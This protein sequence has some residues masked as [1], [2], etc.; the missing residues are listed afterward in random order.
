MDP[1]SPPKGEDLSQA[2]QID[3]NSSKVQP[4]GRGYVLAKG[5]SSER[6]SQGRP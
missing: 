5:S 2:L 4:E 3:V 6:K 1:D